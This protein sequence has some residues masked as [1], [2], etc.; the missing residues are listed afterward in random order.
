MPKPKLN[1]RDERKIVSLRVRDLGPNP[2]NARTHSREQIEQ[3]ARSID[4]FGF[5]NP[6]LIDGNNQILAGHGRVEAAK[7]LGMEHVP[8]LRI[9]HLGAAE[10][11]AYVLADNKLAEKAGWSDEILKIELQELINLHFEVDLTGFSPGEIDALLDTQ[12]SDGEDA[13]DICPEYDPSH[14]VTQTG[15]CWRAGPHLLICGDAKADSR[16]GFRWGK[17]QSCFRW[18]GRST[19]PRLDLGMSRS[20]SKSADDRCPTQ[21]FKQSSL[22]SQLLAPGR[23]PPTS[24]LSSFDLALLW[25]IFEEPGIPESTFA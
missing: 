6:V 25:Q 10:R 24:H 16:L 11:R 1:D 22:T 4:K 13:D 8:T 19:N 23:G 5:T 7:L 15:D 17:F 2:N 20:G 12:H 9:E 18:L 3:I 14:V 21:A